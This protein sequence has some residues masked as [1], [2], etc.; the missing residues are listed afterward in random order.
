MAVEEPVDQVEV[1][2]PTAAGA[3]GQRAGEMRFG[4]GS[5]GRGFLVPHVDP[6]DVPDASKRSEGFAAMPVS[7]VCFSQLDPFQ[8][9]VTRSPVG[10]SR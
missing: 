1:A 6:V 8:V 2:G 5:E 7:T 4:A 3:D 9:M 10:V